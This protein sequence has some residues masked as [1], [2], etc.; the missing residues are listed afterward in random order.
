MIKVERIQCAGSD[1]GLE[2]HRVFNWGILRVKFVD[3][4]RPEN[5]PKV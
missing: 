3:I 4:D 1:Y 2:Y 5:R